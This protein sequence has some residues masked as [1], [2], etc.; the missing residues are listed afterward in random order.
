MRRWFTY[1]CTSVSVLVCKR[2]TLLGLLKKS[3]S[4][5]RGLFQLILSQQTSDVSRK[6]S[7]EDSLPRALGP[8][9]FKNR[10]RY[11]LSGIDSLV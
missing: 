4:Y 2:G 7:D 5:R 3:R 6:S 9:L 8:V 10:V 1:F 11:F